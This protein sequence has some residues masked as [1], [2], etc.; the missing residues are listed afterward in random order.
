M[1]RFL[2]YR[3][4]LIWVAISIALLYFVDFGTAM[5]NARHGIAWGWG[6]PV[7]TAVPPETASEI[8]EAFKTG[9]C[10]PVLVF[11]V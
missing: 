5:Q 6:P 11:S 9:I 4:L 2:I 7:Q 8:E 3:L 10:D 1:D